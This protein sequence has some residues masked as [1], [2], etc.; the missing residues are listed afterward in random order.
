MR[1]AQLMAGAANGGAELF[2]ERM[3]LALH[4]AG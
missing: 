2:F 3:T 1:V 4:E